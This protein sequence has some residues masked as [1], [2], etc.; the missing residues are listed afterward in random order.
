MSDEPVIKPTED[1][2]PELFYSQGDSAYI[3]IQWVND[4]QGFKFSVR[5]QLY[6][7]TESEKALDEGAVALSTLVRGMV[8][9]ALQSTGTVY[10]IGKD[11]QNRDFIALNTQNMSDKEKLMLSDPQGRA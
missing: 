10:Q 1:A 5:N 8:E 7:N 9:I 3:R 11:A 4:V 2:N 6:H